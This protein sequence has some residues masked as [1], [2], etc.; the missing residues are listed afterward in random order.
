MVYESKRPAPANPGRSSLL[1]SLL[2]MN[3]EDERPSD[4]FGYELTF[5]FLLN[6]SYENAKAYPG[7]SETRAS[8]RP[9][10]DSAY[11]S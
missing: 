7:I 1:E 11:T 10:Q 8:P 3:P 5:D 6:L 4:L 9:I 2:K